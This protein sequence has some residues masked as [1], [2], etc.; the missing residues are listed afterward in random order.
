MPL[1][2]SDEPDATAPRL[3][4]AVLWLLALNVAVF[5]VQVT[6][7]GDLPQWL[8]FR[9]ASF[10]RHW[11][12]ALTYM[13][14]HAGFWHLAFNMYMLWAFGPR[15]ERAWSTRGFAGYYLWCGVGGVVAHALLVRDASLLVGAS[16]AI[17]GV[18]LAYA[19]HWPNEEAYLFGVVPMRVKWRVA[20]FIAIDVVAGLSAG[21][22]AAAAAGVD[23]AHWA[24]LGGALFGFL[25]ALR[26]SA[27]NVERLRQRV[28]SAPD[29]GDDPPRP[30][31][32]SLPR[33]R[34]RGSDADEVVE[35]SKAVT[36]RPARPAPV[37]PPRRPVPAATP[38]RSEA[39]D[40]VL[41]KISQHG[42]GS[43][44]TDERTL[45][46]EMSRKLRDS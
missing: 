41:D 20:M 3:S 13:F 10:E 9:A 37:Q 36:A 26:P 38:S 8:G 34:E 21:G 5:F 25:Y 7:Q 15:V 40:L 44:T 19:M 35:K 29:L 1:P 27:P 24:H 18:L 22:G 2:A 43:L 11:W 4:P 30:V 17:Y 32:R 6:V 31:P 33:P 23:T 14:V 46:E 39:L 28:A 16:G 45:L 42:L 12:T